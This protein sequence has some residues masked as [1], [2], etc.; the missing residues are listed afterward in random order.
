LLRFAYAVFVRLL[1][2]SLVA[3]AQTPAA[4]FQEAQSRAAASDWSGAVR[5]YR[6]VL[7]LDPRSAEAWTNLG[8]A[9]FRLQQP[10]EAIEAYQRALRLKPGLLAARLNMGLANLKTGQLPA[11]IADFRAV[12]QS[13]AANRTARQLLANALLEAD[14]H[15]EALQH[16]EQLL[17]SEDVSI[18]LGLAS[19]KTRLGDR[20]AGRRLFAE[21]MRQEDSAA[22]HYA[23]AQ[24]YLAA[25]DLDAARNAIAR[26]RERNDQL[27]GLHFLLGSLYWREQDLPAAMEA[28]RR[29]LLHDRDSFE[30]R[31]ALGALFAQQQRWDEATPL[32]KEARRL[33][34]QHAGSV[35]YLARAAA[36]RGADPLALLREA[37]RLDPN[38]RAAW[39][40]LGQ[41]CRARGL[42]REA[43][44]AFAAVNRLAR[45]QVSEDI[46]ILEKARQ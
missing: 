13:D 23:A 24:A 20:D 22:V 6:Q 41:S 26:A 28:W 42:H 10:A 4:L 2:T 39:Y 34:P 40:L 17:P 46:D 21:A 25:N 7:A 31:F 12:L 29:E 32:L 14:Q 35:F 3:W 1:L 33:R 38:D 44:R 27:P 16:F 9:L 11:A 8:I 19:A 36:A 18:L 43:A 30:A 45:N 15:A 37:V 5:S